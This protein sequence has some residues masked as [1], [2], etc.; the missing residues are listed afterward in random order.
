MEQKPVS[1][2]IVYAD[3]HTHIKD[4]CKEARNR[5]GLTN[6]DIADRISERF[7]IDA[8]SVNT[9]NNFFSD[10]SKATTIFTTGYICAV[11]GISVDAAFGIEH[12]FSSKE[13]AEYVRQLSDLKTE[14]RDKHQYISYMEELIK[15]KDK[16]IE[17]ADTAID[18]YRTE[19]S[20]Q[21]KKAQP[22]GFWACLVLLLG[23]LAFMIAYLIIFDIGN[24]GYGIF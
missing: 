4:L 13:E 11:L 6:Q 19:A 15:E 24:P 3:V 10:R 1:D 21:S 12:E 14:L 20:L 5:M 22:W 2:E 8:F 16:R 18:H 17:Q 7:S 9:V 23:A